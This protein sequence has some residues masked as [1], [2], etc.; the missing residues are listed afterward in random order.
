MTDKTERKVRQWVTRQ[1]GDPVTTRDVIEL[2]L[3][4]DDDSVERHDETIREIATVRQDF[5]V[6]CEH[7]TRRDV[8]ITALEGWRD[9]CPAAV[10]AAVISHHEKLHD[11]HLSAAHAAG[12]SGDAPGADHR[13][14]RDEMAARRTWVMW[15]VGTKIGAV[16]LAVV[17]SVIVTVINVA[18]NYIC[19]GTP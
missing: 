9:G 7:A 15:A 2:V 16:L 5:L 11:R 12:R 17:L 18:L 19:L 8:R 1:N 13:G 3:A 4:S 6:H 14:D 10:Q